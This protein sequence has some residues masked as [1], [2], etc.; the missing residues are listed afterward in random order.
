MFY[1]QRFDSLL[2]RY[3]YYVSLIISRFPFSAAPTL[4]PQPVSAMMPFTQ[5]PHPLP[6]AFPTALPTPAA[7]PQRPAFYPQII[8]WY[9]SPP[10]SPQ[11]YLTNV[12]GPAVIV[13]RGLPFHA[14]VQDILNFFQSFP[15]V[16]QLLFKISVLTKVSKLL[17]TFFKQN[18]FILFGH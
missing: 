14:T 10:L 13:M 12:A 18:L 15:E 7:I 11:S 4:I 5:F 6:A 9:P 2:V 16:R 17:R 3:F 8:Y 1:L